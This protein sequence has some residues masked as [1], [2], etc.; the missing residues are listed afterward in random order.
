MEPELAVTLKRTIKVNSD[1][2]MIYPCVHE[3]MDYR[4]GAKQAT[5]TGRNVSFV[6]CLYM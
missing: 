3:L 5:F 6:L 2:A 1:W 4:D